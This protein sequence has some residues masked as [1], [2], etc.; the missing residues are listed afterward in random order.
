MIKM[1]QYIMLLFLLFISV[2]TVSGFPGMA[3]NSSNTSATMTPQNLTNVT[4]SDE[5]I[6]LL[7]HLIV[8]DSTALG[9][10][11]KIYVQ[12]TLI[13][14]NAGTRNFSGTLRT[15]VQDG[16]EGIR[17]SKAEMM[18]GAVVDQLQ[19]VQNGNIISWRDSIPVNDP[20]P[21]LYSVEYVLPADP[22]LSREKHYSK[23]LFYPTLVTKQPGVFT[24]KITKG[25]TESVA[26]TDEKGSSITASGN[27]GDD[28]YEW[29]MPQFKEV[30]IV[31]TQPAVSPQGIWGYAIIGIL[32]LAALSYPIM[33]KK[34]RKLQEFE[35]KIKSS[36]RRKQKAVEEPGEIEE[37]AVEDL[38]A[39]F[40][41]KVVD[42]KDDSGKTKEELETERKEIISRLDELEKDYS[43][44]NLLDEEYEELK[45]TYK[46][47]V[48]EITGRIE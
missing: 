11:N 42:E 28:R 6:V 23:N 1:K 40:G 44:G 26:I 5:D 46:E 24:I 41:E 2:S 34:S 25:E 7:Q 36:F 30:N 39:G 17:V 9:S 22:A 12:E 43:A 20:L 38:P 27:V 10:E 48:D 33:R 45:K 31:I 19:V 13:Y 47:R 35:E 3:V 16:F 18:T 37:E 21:P 8:V 29:A 14:R 32:I 15:W 4:E